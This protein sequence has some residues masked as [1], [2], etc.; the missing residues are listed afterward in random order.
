MA[1]SA[2]LL[3]PWVLG[4]LVTSY[5][6]P[7]GDTRGSRHPWVVQWPLHTFKAWGNSPAPL[8][9]HGPRGLGSVTEWPAG[10]RCLF[11]MWP[12]PS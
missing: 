8:C 9:A 11:R 6:F 1:L 4:A 7:S 3:E 12:L 5:H 10:V 2:S